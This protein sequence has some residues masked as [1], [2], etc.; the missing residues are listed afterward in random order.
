MVETIL[1]GKP[2]TA[3]LKHGDCVRIWMSD[4]A[5]GSIFGTI[6]QTISN[7]P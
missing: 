7:G 2:E 5:G 3:F 4:A 1:R 6:G